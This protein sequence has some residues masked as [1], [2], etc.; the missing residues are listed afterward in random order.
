MDTG[1][2]TIQE[3]TKS[4][5]RVHNDFDSE[6]GDSLFYETDDEDKNNMEGK[7]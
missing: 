1:A 4:P 2:K 5:R 3:E 6:S 7:N